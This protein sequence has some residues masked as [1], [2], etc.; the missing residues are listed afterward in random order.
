[1]M[2][3]TVR[4]IVDFLQRWA[5]ADLKL[6]YDN[7]GLQA[8]NSTDKV[9]GVLTTL[10]VTEAVIDEA[11]EKKANLIVAHHPII[12]P[13]IPALTEETETG[14]LIVKLIRNGI[15]L[16]VAHTNLDSVKG[17]VSFVLAE[18]L[19]LNNTR[20]LSNGE[21][22]VQ[23]VEAQVSSDKKEELSQ[24]IQ[25]NK[26]FIFSS[27]ITESNL[28]II[29]I[30]LV[31]DAVFQSKCRSFLQEI[32]ATQIFI[33]L[34]D[35]KNPNYGFGVLGEFPESGLSKDEFFD[36]VTT[37]LGIQTFRFSG[38][39]QNIKTVAVCGGAGSSLIKKAQQ[40]QADAY[41][42]S[43][44]KYHDYFINQPNFM[45]L[46]IGHFETERF[47][48]KTLHEQIQA[49]FP[50]IQV[51]TS[52]VFTNPMQTFVHQNFIN[53]QIKPNTL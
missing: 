22:K 23:R 37:N 35:G 46:D 53:Q 50:E 15:N 17:G 18:T 27:L 45:L 47:I 7:V 42:T 39:S 21:G 11:I 12:F 36:R 49:A 16:F 38:D 19:G 48:A 20:F 32:S 40:A 52:Q 51:Q 33:S 10:D 6:S 26:E 24:F 13:T 28:E 41:I 1:M 9:K 3:V 5:P 14:R 29:G 43:D 25:E 8:G 34:V 30:Q 44:I 4:H 2:I 31:I